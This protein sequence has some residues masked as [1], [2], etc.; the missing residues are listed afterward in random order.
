M[1]QY[2]RSWPT[3]LLNYWTT[4]LRQPQRHLLPLHRGQSVSLDPLDPPAVFILVEFQKFLYIPDLKMVLIFLVRKVLQK[5]I[6]FKMSLCFTLTRHS[7]SRNVPRQGVMVAWVCTAAPIRPVAAQLN[8]PF[9]NSLLT[10]EHTA[11]WTLQAATTLGVMA[12][13]ILVLVTRFGK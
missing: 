9:G 8:L 5:G 1:E 3:E 2:R 7:M 6:M 11:A 13:K 4:E 10:I 12:I